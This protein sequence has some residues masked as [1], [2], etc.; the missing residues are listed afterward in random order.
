MGY[1]KVAEGVESEVVCVCSVM[2][3]HVDVV[4]VWWQVWL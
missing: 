2:R 4:A 1:A 3:H